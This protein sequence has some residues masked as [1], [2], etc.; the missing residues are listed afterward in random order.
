MSTQP[1]R[2]R[3]TSLTPAHELIANQFREF[4]LQHNYPC[5][6]A[7]S[8]LRNNACR[9]EHY[10]SLGTLASAQALATDLKHFTQIRKEMHGSFATFV[11]IF[12]RPTDT[13]EEQ[14]ETLLWKQLS[15]LHQV[16][17]CPWSAAAAI[18]PTSDNFGFS[19]G[20]EAFFIVGLH[21]RSAR[22]ARRFA[23]PTLVFN[24]HSQFEQLRKESK[25][26]KMRQIIRSRDRAWQGSNNPM[27]ADYG[28]TSEARQYSGRAV[29]TD[30]RCPFLHNQIT[31]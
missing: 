29:P 9:I 30:W 31:P 15:A 26:E 27:L 19:F 16:D 14:F 21:A 4:V 5:L 8:A 1:E 22:W 10:A 18:D 28:T 24:A 3:D 6:G 25:F 12:D 23:Q 20:S 13:S 2:P 7:K 17:D 11:A